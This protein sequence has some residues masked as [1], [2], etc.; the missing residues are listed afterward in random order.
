[1]RTIARL[2]AAL[3]SPVAVILYCFCAAIFS[4]SFGIYLIAGLGWSLIAAS[5]PLFVVAYILA[6]GLGRVR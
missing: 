6:R 1:M 2:I 4:A 3:L 5:V